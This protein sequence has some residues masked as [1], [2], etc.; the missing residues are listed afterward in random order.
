[1]L[2]T[3]PVNVMMLFMRLLSKQITAV[4]QKD[5]NEKQ[6]RKS[7]ELNWTK[8]QHKLSYIAKFRPEKTEVQ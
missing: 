1:M 5:E 8:W 4:Q 6:E 7:L 3:L 2:F